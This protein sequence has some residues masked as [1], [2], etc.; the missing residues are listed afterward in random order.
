SNIPCNGTGT[1]S[2]N[3]SG[4][5]YTTRYQ[6][7]VVA[8]M[9]S[10]IPFPNFGDN[11]YLTN[12]QTFKFSTAFDPSTPTYSFRTDN[13]RYLNAPN[14]GGGDFTATTAFI[15]PLTSQFKIIDVN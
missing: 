13:G 15:S 14:G 1:C 8:K 9:R 6:W 11:V 3:V 7:R 4:L 10:A 2:V 12:S 5:A